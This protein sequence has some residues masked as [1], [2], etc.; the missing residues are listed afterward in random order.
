MSFANWK[1]GTRLGAGFTVVLVS[2]VG[3]MLLS[4]NSMS[5]MGANTHD[6]VADK[7]LKMATVS[8]MAGD[9]R[10]MTLAITNMVGVPGFAAMKLHS[11]KL[12]TA[13][14]HYDQAHDTYA[15]LVSS[16]EEK[17]LLATT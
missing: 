17:A 14:G 9:V 2:L 4:L 5:R 12:T 10:D 8:T 11:G 1:I 7:N 3:I 15:K 6:I 16:N 13:L